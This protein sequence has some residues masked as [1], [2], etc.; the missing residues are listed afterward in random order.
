[1]TFEPRPPVSGIYQMR[2][3]GQGVRL[4]PLPPLTSPSC[5][6]VSLLPSRSGA[7]FLRARII[8]LLFP[9]SL[10]SPLYLLPSPLFP[11]PTPSSPSSRPIVCMYVCQFRSTLPDPRGTGQVLLL[12]SPAP[13]SPTSLWPCPPPQMT[14]ANDVEPRLRAVIG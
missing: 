6:F 1:M 10:F 12:P 14:S 11:P 4:S 2:G 13:S 9:P 3:S 5:P 7:R 8:C